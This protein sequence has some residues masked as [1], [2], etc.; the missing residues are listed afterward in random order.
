MT[1]AVLEEAPRNRDCPELAQVPWLD[2]QT[3][4]ELRLAGARF[5]T[6][7]GVE[8]PLF[9]DFRFNVAECFAKTQVDMDAYS[10]RPLNQKIASMIASIGVYGAEARTFPRELRVPIIERFFEA[11][12]PLVEIVKDERTDFP[13]RTYKEG[14]EKR[15]WD[16]TSF[17]LTDRITLT[18]YQ[19][20][21]SLLS[22]DIEVRDEEGRLVEKTRAHNGNIGR[23]ERLRYDAEGN[24]AQYV[25]FNVDDRSPSVEV[26]WFKEGQLVESREI[27][28]YHDASGVCVKVSRATGQPGKWC[29]AKYTNWQAAG[30]EFDQMKVRGVDGDV[31]WIRD[32]GLSDSNPCADTHF[33]QEQ[34]GSWIGTRYA[35]MY[36]SYCDAPRDRNGRI[37]WKSLEFGW[38]D[39]IIVTKKGRNVEIS[40][41]DGA[42]TRLPREINI[43]QAEQRLLAHAL[44]E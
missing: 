33:H 43:R 15:Q 18:Q 7:V 38:D 31:A 11:V 22:N 12:S 39:P 26:M 28:Y 17:E 32:V 8:F 35:L 23:W 34:E 36:R 3:R 13:T 27:S 6:D 5:N 9:A 37:K 10:E 1:P 24:V 40:R 44:Y 14:G 25:H 20:F 41:P 16:V 42:K 2:E 29:V 19:N 30:L 21:P 4:D